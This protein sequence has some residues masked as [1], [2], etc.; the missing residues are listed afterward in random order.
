MNVKMLLFKLNAARAW[1][2]TGSSGAIWRAVDDSAAL[3]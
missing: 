1:P 3:M 2:S